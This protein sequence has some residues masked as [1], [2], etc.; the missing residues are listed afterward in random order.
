MFSSFRGSYDEV[1]SSSSSSSSARDSSSSKLGGA[2][3]GGVR[4]CSAKFIPRSAVSSSR[5]VQTG[6]RSPKETRRKCHYNVLLLGRTITTKHQERREGSRAQHHVACFW[7]LASQHH[8]GLFSHPSTNSSSSSGADWSLSLVSVTLCSHAPHSND[9]AAL[10]RRLPL[11]IVKLHALLARHYALE[12]DRQELRLAM[13]T[14]T[15]RSSTRSASQLREDERERRRV[16]L[17][18]TTNHNQPHINPQTVLIERVGSS[19]ERWTTLEWTTTTT[20][21]TTEVFCAYGDLT[22]QQSHCLIWNGSN[23]QHSR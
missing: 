4:S 20:R 3:L 7:Y 8:T 17:P 5:G 11:T 15:C 23:E 22:N 10:H 13:P 18:T 19:R 6:T 16:C 14:T 1:S 2:S 9:M 12:V 21:N